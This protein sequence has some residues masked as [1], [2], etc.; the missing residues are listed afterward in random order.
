MRKA[1]GRGVVGLFVSLGH[2]ALAT[3]AG[4]PVDLVVLDEHHHPIA[5]AAVQIVPGSGLI[6]KLESDPEG[7]IHIDRVMPGRYDLTVTHDG[8]HPLIK[9]ELELSQPEVI[10]L[11]LVAAPERHEHIDVK[12]DTSA[13]DAGSSAPTQIA[14]ATVRE[15]PSHPATVSDALPLVPGVVR[16][17]A[18]DLQIS[19]AGEHRSALIVNSADVTDPATGQFGL[20]VPIDSVESVNVYQT[21]FLAEF[22]RFTAGLVSVETRRGGEQ[23]KWEIN[24]PFPDFRIRSYHLRGLRDA[25]PRVNVEGPLIRGKLYFSEGLEY[26]VRKIQV[27]TLP[28]PQNQKVTEGVN[29]FAQLDWVVSS[30]QLVT[31]TAHIA[32]QRMSYVNLDFFNPQSTVPDAA[33]HNYT[34]TIADR[35][36]LWG[37]LVETTFSTTR[38][39]ANIWRQGNQDMVLAPWGN[40][41]NYFAQQRRDAVRYTGSPV[42]TF[43]SFNLLGAHTFKMGGAFTSSSEQGQVSDQPIDIVDARNSVR[44]RITF[45]GGRAFEMDDVEYAFFGQDHW[46]ISSRL[47]ADLGV[48]TESQEISQSFRVAPRAG[49]AWA[50][51]AN[52]RTVVRAGFGLFFDRVPL[53]VYSFNHY[54]RQNISFFDSSGNLTAGPYYFENALGVTNVHSPFVIHHQTPGDYSPRSANGSIQIEQTVTSFLKLRASYMRD[55]SAGLVILDRVSPDPETML[56]AYE[57]SGNGDSRYR[58]LEITGRLSLT[59]SRLLLLSYVHSMA[60]GDLNEFA[61]Y[62]GSFPSPIIRDNLYTRL[63]T[64]LPNRFLAWGVVPLPLGFRVA[65]AFEIRDGF[66]YATYNGLQDYAGQ[67]YAQ[68]Y[69][70]FVSMDS[71][72]S[73]DIRVN[74]KYTVRLSVSGYNLS[75]H[76]NPEAF[77][78]NTG[79]P[80]YGLFFGHR[81][82]RFT[83]DF[84]VLF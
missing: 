20:T 75:N 51:F 8:F 10:E 55:E 60:Q 28:F 81:G 80:A 45:S 16:T 31:A 12:A 61:G 17:P 15:L 33:T 65:P 9:R 58:Q 25:T 84:D 42:Y 44:E 6:G 1:V 14:S 73:K 23:W 3:P 63:P 50:P 78:A 82:R 76:F 68:R 4:F 40:H 24:D 21:P 56:G 27:Y 59:G 35:L 64:D 19:G 26:E 62:L 36:T 2:I 41:G 69:P 32:P 52:A 57:L 13:A 34:A 49:L 48:R 43:H 70:R 18:G 77:H 22:G 47:A 71:R 11:I 72:F 67:P 7:R 39:D 53:N 46:S 83:A 54:P 29:S 38:F 66:P 37:G 74:T 30:R 79:D 5:A